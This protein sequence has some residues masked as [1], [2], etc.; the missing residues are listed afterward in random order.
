MQEI[1]ELLKQPPVIG[2]CITTFIG[3]AISNYRLIKGRHSEIARERLEKVYFPI[4]KILHDYFF[5]YSPDNKHFWEAITK[6]QE[7]IAENELIAGN[8]ICGLLE[9]FLKS[10][11]SKKDAPK[12]FNELCN[13]ILDE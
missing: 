12:N 6:V 8:K 2:A 7:I 3:G 11:N 9:S 13:H 1:I 4:F 5:K 10:R